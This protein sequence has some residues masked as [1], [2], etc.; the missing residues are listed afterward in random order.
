MEYKYQYN[1][2]N[3]RD[4]ILSQ[5]KDKVFLEE[6]NI[7]EG[8]FLI[9]GDEPR[10]PAVFITKIEV[11]EEEFNKLQSENELLRT[12]IF[13]MTTYAASQ[14]ERIVRQEQ[15]ILELTTLIAGGNA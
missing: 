15:S 11:N 12:S 8:N 4:I 13:E 1:T 14:D 6:L 9:L 5:N 3:E 2:D 7:T 10:P